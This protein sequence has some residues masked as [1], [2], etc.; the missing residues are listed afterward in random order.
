M[1]IGAK[2]SQPNKDVRTAADF[3]L[4]L[5]SSFPLL[6]IHDSG[7]ITISA[8]SSQDISHSLGYPPAFWVFRNWS[9]DSDNEVYHGD[10]STF[11]SYTGLSNDSVLTIDNNIDSS[12]DFYYYI[13]RQDLTD[14]FSASTINT[15][16][17]TDDAIDRDYGIKVSKS[18]SSIASTDLRDYA[19]HS[20]TRSPIIHKT[21]HESH[22]ASQD[23][24]VVTHTLTHNLGYTPLGFA[25]LNLNPQD[26]NDKYQMITDAAGAGGPRFHLGDTEISLGVT[27]GSEGGEANTALIC[28]KDPFSKN[29]TEV[30]FNG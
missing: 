8:N 4:L 2:V 11:A 5:S 16:A 10:F 1:D 30:N 6:K 14:P 19:I 3:E 15:E 29:V 25:Y 23:F 18:G 22:V 21:E 26:G 13:F 17:S 12:T 9:T 7:P 27:I 20:G 24:D 28:L